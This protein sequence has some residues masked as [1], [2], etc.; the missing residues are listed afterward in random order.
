MV[1]AQQPDDIAR[2]RTRQIFRFLKAFAERNVP[3]VRQLASHEWSFPLRSLP[4]Y[5]SITLGAVQLTVG[6]AVSAADG[7][8]SDNALLKI[9][10]PR[11]TKGPTP[12]DSL[13]QWIQTGWD[14]PSLPPTVATTLNTRRGAEIVAEE[15]EAL[16]ARTNAFDG[17]M[18]RW[19]AWAMAERPARAAQKVF[20]QFYSLRARLEQ[21]SET[22]EL[23]LG[24]GRLVWQ[25]PDG[26]VDHPVLLQRVELEFDPGGADPE[27]RVVDADRLPE[28]NGQLL[29]SENGLAVGDLMKFSGELELRGYHP[30]EDAATTEFLRRLVQSLD[31]QGQFHAEWGPRQPVAAPHMMRDPVLFMRPRQSGFP[32]AFDRVLEDLETG[33]TVPVALSALAGIQTLAVTEHET[34]WASP[35]NEPADV[36]L[37]KPANEQQVQIAQALDRYRAVLVQ[38]P[39]GTGKSHTI[40][41]LIGHLV[42][43]GLRVL[44][45]SHTPRALR[46]LRGQVDETLRPLCVAVLDTDLES[47]KQM[48]ESVRAI[49]SAYP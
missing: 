27:I 49:L 44:V 19:D 6:D 21:E 14:D 35:W 1:T 32:A 4:T 36:F 20:E 45:T 22:R 12:P 8:A 39:P 47:R 18:A 33:A 43:K 37:S 26:A 13:M 31:A 29:R 28:L 38:G 10:R 2:Q 40:A 25:S 30:M 41:N 16:P 42:A 17:W 9:R 46:V 48:E 23:V 5:P 34:Q 24:D 11:I 7:A 15:F 3:T